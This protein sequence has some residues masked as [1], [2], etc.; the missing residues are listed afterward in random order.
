MVTIAQFEQKQREHWAG[1]REIDLIVDSFGE[2][3][4]LKTLAFNGCGAYISG[5]SV[6]GMSNNLAYHVILLGKPNNIERIKEVRNFCRGAIAA[7]R[8]R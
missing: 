7:Y 6:A 2:L 4:W 3:V 1:G 8:Q 5:I